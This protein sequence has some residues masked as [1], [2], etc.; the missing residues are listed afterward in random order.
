[1]LLSVA[2]FGI[3]LQSGFTSSGSCTWTALT[4]LRD[5]TGVLLYL[6]GYTGIYAEHLVG[7]WF[8]LQATNC[9]S[10]RAGFFGD[11]LHSNRKDST[12]YLRLFRW[13]WYLPISNEKLQQ[14]VLYRR[15]LDRLTHRE[16]VWLP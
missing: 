16:F 7:T 9:T 3:R 15:Q 12:S 11:F 1:M 5:T 8:R 13:S 4:V 14:V 10:C 6:P 2:L